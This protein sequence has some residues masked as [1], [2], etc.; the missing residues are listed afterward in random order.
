MAHLHHP[1]V[2][3]E[4]HDGGHGAQGWWSSSDM[5]LGAPRPGPSQTKA[6]GQWTLPHTAA[7][8]RDE[9]PG[10][11]AHRRESGSPRPLG[12]QSPDLLACC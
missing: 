2:L 9:G 7:G 8:S 10:P 5:Y 6:W 12:P 3:A 1:T 11:R 4:A